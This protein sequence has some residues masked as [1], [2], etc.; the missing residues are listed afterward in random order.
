MAVL[1][2]RGRIDKLHS[3]EAAGALPDGG[4]PA[5]GLIRALD[6]ADRE[7]VLRAFLLRGH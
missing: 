3:P 4:E 1:I 5:P 6:A 2:R 7:A